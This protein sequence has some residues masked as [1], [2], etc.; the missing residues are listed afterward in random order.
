[1]GELLRNSYVVLEKYLNLLYK[2]PEL[3]ELYD[4]VLLFVINF[5]KTLLFAEIAGE[6]Y[7]S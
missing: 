7:E 1:M 3:S 6:N 4:L 5:H 2:Y